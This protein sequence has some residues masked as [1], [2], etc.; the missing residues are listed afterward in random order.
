VPAA[1][2]AASSFASA[3]QPS[4]H[5]RPQKA[6]AKGKHK[7]QK[8]RHCDNCGSD[9]HNRQQCPVFTR[10]GKAAALN[11]A[12][13]HSHRHAGDDGE[14][15]AAA[16]ARRQSIIS[17]LVMPPTSTLF[18]SSPSAP[19]ASL[20]LPSSSSLPAPSS[21]SSSSRR[22][23]VTAQLGS[24]SAWTAHSSAVVDDAEEFE[25]SQP[26][27]LAPSHGAS[28]SGDDGGGGSA[29]AVKRVIR[30]STLLKSGAA[31]SVGDADS[32]ASGSGSGSAMSNYHQEEVE[33]LNGHEQHAASPA[34]GKAAKRVFG[35][36]APLGTD[37]ELAMRRKRF[38][39][40][41]TAAAATS[42][43]EAATSA[44]S[45]ESSSSST[46]VCYKC[47]I[48]GH[49]RSDCPQA[50]AQSKKKKRRVDD[51][52]PVDASAD[53]VND[54]EA[55][56]AGAGSGGSARGASGYV[57]HTCGIPGH[58]RYKCP[59]FAANAQNTSLSSSL[60]SANDAADADADAGGDADAD[61]RG[62]DDGDARDDGDD[63]DR[64]QHQHKSARVCSFCQAVGHTRSFCFQL[65]KQAKHGGRGGRGGKWQ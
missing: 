20:P 60:S 42:S 48:P 23:I 10:A 63:G 51:S 35:K 44:D 1:S 46:Y 34:A 39:L 52:E 64:R 31:A 27:R 37:N 13:A 56:A 45:L 65:K 6:S 21:A 2:A 29:P 15:A 3:E 5:E 47:G 14:D 30:A 61:G 16:A 8:P 58:P 40:D 11:A 24:A 17:R 54:A 28:A 50:P 33:A 57:C 4:A 55:E 38:G 43:S 41:E 49:K 18:A 25:R 19:V 22:M 36:L 9:D 7:L 26:Q 59:T 62:D 12:H 53:A 32:N